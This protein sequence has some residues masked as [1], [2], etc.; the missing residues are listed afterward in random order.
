MS[1]QTGTGS[2]PRQR[3]DIGRQLVKLRRIGT[4]IPDLIELIRA[5]HKISS[6]IVWGCSVPGEL[7]SNR[8]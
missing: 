1:N 8:L 6:I 2:M 3:H 5:A 4:S 7:D